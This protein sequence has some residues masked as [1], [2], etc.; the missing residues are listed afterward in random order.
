MFSQSIKTVV[1]LALPLVDSCSGVTRVMKLGGGGTRAEGNRTSRGF[2][3]CSPKKFFI[4]G[5]LKNAIFNIFRQVYLKSKS[6]TSVIFQPVRNV[7]NY[8]L[9]P[10]FHFGFKNL[11]INY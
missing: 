10:T 1:G 5:F 6:D 3:A 11:K 4:S 9:P 7:S 8:R 2:R